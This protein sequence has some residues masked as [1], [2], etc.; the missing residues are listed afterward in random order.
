MKT[1]LIL[2]IAMFCSVFVDAHAAENDGAQKAILITGASSGFG[3]ATAEY[4]AKRGYLVY[5]GA[6]KSEDIEALGRIENIRAIRLDVTDQEDID[7]AVELVRAEGSGL[8]GLV[9]NAGVLGI[10]PMTEVSDEDVWFQYNVNV[11]GVIRVT[12]AFAPLIIESEGR[13]V[14]VS[15]ISGVISAGFAGVY[16]S[17]KHAIEA[18][19]DSLADEMGKFNVHVAAVNPGGFSTEIGASY[20]SRMSAKDENWGPFEEVRQ[21]ELDYCDRESKSDDQKDTNSLIP[22]A[23]VIEKALFAESPM[24]RY[25]VV[26]KT[27]EAESTI[28]HGMLEMLRLNAGY[29]DSYSREELAELMNALWPYANG[30]EHWKD[31]DER[32]KFLDEWREKERR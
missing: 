20:C 10:A 11:F 1:T 19:T 32:W 15:S 27:I 21:S 6:R 7:A 28:A 29:E 16:A 13:I 24:T 26:E 8:W 3:R 17:S 23:M 25:L 9:N 31:P 12:R 2:A 30:S 14:N 4:L 22:V 5:A 18:I